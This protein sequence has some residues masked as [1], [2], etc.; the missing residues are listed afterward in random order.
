LR[1]RPTFTIE[2]IRKYHFISGSE[3]D[4]HSVNFIGVAHDKTKFRQ[5]LKEKSLDETLWRIKRERAFKAKEEK[6]QSK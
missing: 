2:N 3:E 4:E 5:P 1:Q 6:K